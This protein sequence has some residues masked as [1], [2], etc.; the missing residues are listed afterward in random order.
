HISI[1]ASEVESET[2][3]KYMQ[4]KKQER[5][6]KAIDCILNDPNVNELIDKFDASVIMESITPSN[7]SE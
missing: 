1:Q 6:Q 3:Q 2:P 7:A 4:R 5:Q